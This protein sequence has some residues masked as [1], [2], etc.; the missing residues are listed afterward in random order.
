[1]AAF[2]VT[3]WGGKAEREYRR[4]CP[5]METLPWDSLVLD[6]DPVVLLAARTEWTEAAMQEHASAAMAAATLQKLVLA[7]TPIDL[8]GY[9]ARVPS[10]ELVHAELCAR[11]A[12]ALGGAAALAWDRTPV[13]VTGEDLLIEAA[14]H[15]VAEMCVKES[16]SHALLKAL[17]VAERAQPLQRLVW[18]RILVDEVHHAGIGWM[19]LE[20]AL[21]E[22]PDSARPRLRAAAAKTAAALSSE[23]ERV[24]ALPELHFSPLGVIGVLGRDGF[25]TVGREALEVRVYKPLRRL[26]LV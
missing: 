16:W 18:E 26:E 2:E 24:A 4:A 17:S 15:V 25:A 12:L 14:E 9:F 23:I 7:G 22:L 10:D 5:E 11:M 8:C 20:W 6:G 21:G 1:M 3:L 13:T 19:F